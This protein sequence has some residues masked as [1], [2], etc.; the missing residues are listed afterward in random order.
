MAAV[1]S[2]SPFTRSAKQL[3]GVSDVH[4]LHHEHLTPGRAAGSFLV[5]TQWP[6]PKP[7]TH[8]TCQRLRAT[9]P[10]RKRTAPPSYSPTAASGKESNWLATPPGKGYF[11]ILRFYG[12]TE[13]A[14]DKRRKPGDI[15]KRN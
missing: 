9:K 15:E 1:V 3:A 11:A 7:K 10:C 5:A 14:I 12:P 8:P 2:N 4:L 13:A 6:W